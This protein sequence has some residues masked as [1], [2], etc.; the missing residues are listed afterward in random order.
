MVFNDLLKTIAS[1]GK[2]ET[3]V[4]KVVNQLKQE[5]W[6]NKEKKLKINDLQKISLL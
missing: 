4:N 2:M 6:S 3:L 1:M 5:K